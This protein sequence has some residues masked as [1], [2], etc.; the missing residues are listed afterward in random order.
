MRVRASD[1]W[2]LPS[3]LDPGTSP[4]PR[5]LA[6]AMQYAECSLSFSD[7]F[8]A[9]TGYALRTVTR[10]VRKEVCDDGILSTP[11]ATNTCH[12]T[13]ERQTSALRWNG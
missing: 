5:S 11:I 13:L 10:T 12:L 3:S 1:S 9:P 2:E 8:S 6:A 7:S 4:H